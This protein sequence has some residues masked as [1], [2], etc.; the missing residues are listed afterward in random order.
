M[1][2]KFDFVAAYSITD[3]TC[4]TGAVE[5]KELAVTF[6]KG[7]AFFYILFVRLKAFL[8]IMAKNSFAMCLDVR[9]NW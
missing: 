6:D 2:Q 7:N 4:G 5:D 3:L 1:S 9:P 8:G